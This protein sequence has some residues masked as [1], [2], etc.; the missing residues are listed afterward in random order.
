MIALI[1]GGIVIMNMMLVSVSERTREIGIRKALGARGRDITLQFLVESAAMALLGGFF[2]VM[3]GLGLA[4][5]CDAGAGVPVHGDGVERC[6]GPGDG[7]RHGN[8]LR[9]VSGVEGGAPGPDCGVAVGA[10]RAGREQGTT[11]NRR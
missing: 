1:V 5:G 6:C 8:F 4:R 3:I 10:L 11:G 9:G 2:G 7:D